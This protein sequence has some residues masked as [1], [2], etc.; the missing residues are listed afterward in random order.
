M[1]N[2]AQAYPSLEHG[3]HTVSA[4]PLA[5]R[6]AWAFY[7][8]HPPSSYLVPALLS[9][10]LRSGVRVGNPFTEEYEETEMV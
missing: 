10:C 5:A 6:G 7:F 9:A 3:A 1:H 2:L 4:T 8:P